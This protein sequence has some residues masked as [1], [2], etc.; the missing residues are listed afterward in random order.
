MFVSK[1]MV[2]E[3]LSRQI[4]ILEPFFKLENRKIEIVFIPVTQE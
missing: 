4:N 1:N 3:L 2:N